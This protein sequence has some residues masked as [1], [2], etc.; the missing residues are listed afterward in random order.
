M[1][2]PLAWTVAAVALVAAVVIANLPSHERGRPSSAAGPEP[3]AAAPVDEPLAAPPDAPPRVAL[4]EDAPTPAAQE[5]VRTTVELTVR[6]LLADVPGP[7]IAGARV[8]AVRGRDE[9]E[10]G[11]TDAAG[12]LAAE[13]PGPG[14][15]R[16]ELAPDSLPP[17]LHG[18]GS[19][20]TAG[21][22][23]R[24][25]S[26]VEHDVEAGER[27]ECTVWLREVRTL[28]GLVVDPFGD[29]VV[30][31]TVQALSAEP[32]LE[33]VAQTAVT[34][35]AGAFLLDALFP[36]AYA[37][38]IQHRGPPTARLRDGRALAQLALPPPM[39]L[40]LRDGSRDGVVLRI[41]AG[42]VVVLG[43][44][45][46]E[47]G[48]PFEGL[49]VTASYTGPAN[50]AE[51]V[52]ASY[53]FT[54]NDK[55]GRA[56]TDRGGRFRLEGL[57]RA[58]LRIQVGADAASNAGPERRLLARGPDSVELALADSPRTRYDLGD[59]E[60]LRSHPYAVSGQL[61][62]TAER[63]GGKRLRLSAMVVDGAFPADAEPAEA[64]W[65]IQR[66]PYAQYD[67]STGAFRVSCDTPRERMLLRVYPYGRE[68]LVK[69]LVFYPQP[70]F[71]ER[72]VE[73][74][75]P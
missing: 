10:L 35:A 9:V 66:R 30:G 74:A 54:W 2:H 47:T 64:G 40:D 16:F 46:D 42:D 18:P 31:A 20:A 1:K 69:E 29:P 56:K 73:L 25:I 43:R 13:L 33:S 39:F 22:P 52:A 62:L 55:A 51:P 21:E 38:R 70:D 65:G 14:R 4:T 23:R 71:E 15:Y 60:V 67:R 11:V 58:P 32:G 34:D 61:V 44:V 8:A 48:L 41:T 28:S 3:G 45:V 50:A 26:A 53:R 37:L 63:F 72:D 49:T 12:R 6:R 24:G 68:E 75:Y 7:A 5:P 17:G 27:L 19:F 57:H 59:I 36:H